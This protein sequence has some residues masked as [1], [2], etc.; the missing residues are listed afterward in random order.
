VKGVRLSTHAEHIGV[1]VRGG[2]NVRRVATAGDGA[3][4]D[5]G[6]LGGNDEG[7]KCLR[8][9][10]QAEDVDFE[11]APRLVDVGVQ[12]RHDEAAAG[13]VDQV[14]EGPAGLGLDGVHGGG[15]AGG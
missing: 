4:V 6:A 15:D 7:G 12:D 8:H 11:H 5:N 13:V 3:I 9:G 1:V 2:T 10:Q 14:V